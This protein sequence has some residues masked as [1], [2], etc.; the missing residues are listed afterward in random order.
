MGGRSQG[1]TEGREDQ[2]ET[3]KE[4]RNKGG[5]GGKK[6]MIEEEG[7]ERGQKIE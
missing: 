4:R 2:K 6:G 5:L 3:R 1:R 7:K